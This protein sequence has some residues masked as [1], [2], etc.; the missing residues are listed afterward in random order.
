MVRAS[1]REL[2]TCWNVTWTQLSCLESW[3]KTAWLASLSEWSFNRFFYLFN[4]AWQPTLSVGWFYST[5]YEKFGSK[6]ATNVLGNLTLSGSTGEAYNTDRICT[7]VKKSEKCCMGILHFVQICKF[8]D[9]NCTKMRL[10]A[11][12]CPDRLGEL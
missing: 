9:V 12:L 11:E 8:S 4:Q 1:L 2:L 5:I 6:N 10:A 7:L 3:L